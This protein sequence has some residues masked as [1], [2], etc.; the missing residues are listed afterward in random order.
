MMLGPMVVDD[1]LQRVQLLWQ[2]VAALQPIV[3]NWHVGSDSQSARWNDQLVHELL[4]HSAA[5]GIAM[6]AETHRGRA[7]WSAPATQESV[8]TSP[9]ICAYVPDLSHWCCVH[10][11]LLERFQPAVAAAVER[12]D[13]IHARVGYSQGPQVPHWRAPEWQDAL[14]VHLSWWDAIVAARQAEGC[15]VIICPEFGPAP[16]QPLVPFTA[17]PV[18]DNWE[19]NFSMMCMLRER[20]SK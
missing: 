13:L 1:S 7:T 16:Y 10:E 2:Q 4:E 14:A 20:Y 15:D 12:S 18:S 8:A 19:L 11:S 9:K 17:Q 6:V 3:V 5:T